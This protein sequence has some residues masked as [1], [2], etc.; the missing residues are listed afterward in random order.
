[1]RA[2]TPRVRARLRSLAAGCGVALAT[3]A[4]FAGTA[5]AAGAA[6]HPMTASVPAI[7][8]PS[9]L[10]MD[11]GNLW[12]TNR[13]N[14]TVTEINVRH[15][16]KVRT[17]GGGAY[18]LSS[19]A[20]IIA[21]GF[22][23]WVANEGNNSVD[24]INAASGHLVKRL[25]A[26]S[27][28]FSKPVALTFDGP[29]VFVVNKGGSVTEVGRF[30][31]GLIRHIAG[32]S[33]DFT[34]PVAIASSGPSLWV[35][36][37]S[38]GTQGAVTELSART[39]R[40]EK[41]LT[42]TT[43]NG[44]DHPAGVVYAAGYIWASDYATP[45]QAAYNDTAISATTALVA[46]TFGDAQGAYGFDQPTATVAAGDEVYVLDPTGPSPMVTQ[47]AA[48]GSDPAAHWFECDTNSPD[49]DF[50][51]PDA[52]VLDGNDIF[53]ASTEKRAWGPGNEISEVELTGGNNNGAGAVHWILNRGS[54]G[55]EWR[56]TPTV[57]GGP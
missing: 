16:R 49:P 34:D 5:P 56:D 2:T 11:N 33:Y 36:D 45:D 35:A 24:V 1:M 53:V 50:A 26:S 44:L 19:P 46:E 17:L 10:A 27:F 9:G 21:G 23:L 31:F 4:A 20:A 41:V 29:D 43:T 8:G 52:M 38:A 42:G 47:F 12:I 37:E 28:G 3:G 39:G 40:L 22:N 51:Y 14:S 48:N 32:S 25:S 15:Q 30:R 57:I 18:G 55:I 6:N 54:G 13:W 7:D